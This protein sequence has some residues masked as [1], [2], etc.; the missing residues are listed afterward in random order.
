MFKILYWSDLERN[1]FAYISY[2]GQKICFC[3]IKIV[4][5][6]TPATYSIS[7]VANT[8]YTT[9]IGLGYLFIHSEKNKFLRMMN[10]NLIN[11]YIVD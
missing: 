1:T 4:S 6:Q 3:N 10:S 9:L 8:A 7:T 5:K 2:N 11:Q